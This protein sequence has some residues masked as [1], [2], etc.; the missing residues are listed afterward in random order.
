MSSVDISSA[1]CHLEP[2]SERAKNP[3]E[4]LGF[5]GRNPERLHAI[6]YSVVPFRLGDFY[7][8][9]VDLVLFIEKIKRCNS[10]PTS[11]ST[12]ILEALLL[13]LSTNTIPP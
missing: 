6:G 2:L 1:A 9:F 10:L 8:L 12:S 7:R 3:L 4:R 11:T 5:F 13:S